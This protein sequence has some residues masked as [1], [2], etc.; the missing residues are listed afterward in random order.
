MIS[1]EL[2]SAI[3]LYQMGIKRSGSLLSA[4]TAFVAMRLRLRS[5]LAGAIMLQASLSV[6]SSSAMHAVH[7][8]ARKSPASGRTL[9]N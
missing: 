7:E 1:S 2:L 6:A 3:V 9:A 5:V 4:S 8:E